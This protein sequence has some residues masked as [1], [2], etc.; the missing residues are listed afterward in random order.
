[1]LYEK[2]G[3]WP[4][5]CNYDY[6][7][8]RK[9]HNCHDKAVFEAETTTPIKK[10]AP[11]ATITMPACVIEYVSNF[12]ADFCRFAIGYNWTLTTA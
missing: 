8:K 10:S 11:M 4:M 6:T 12:F 3:I 9:I 5:R 1:M 2:K 7:T